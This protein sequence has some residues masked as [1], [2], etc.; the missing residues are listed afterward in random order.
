MEYENNCINFIIIEYEIINFEYIYA[1][2]NNDNCNTKA[3]TNR[4]I[5]NAV[6]VYDLDK[7]VIKLLEQYEAVVFAVEFEDDK[8]LINCLPSNI[9]Y[10]DFSYGSKFNKPIYNYPLLEYIKFGTDFNQSIEYLPITLIILITGSMFNNKV[11]NLPP[12]IKYISLS[13]AFNQCIDTLSDNV[14]ILEIYGNFQQTIN[15]LPEQLEYFKI[16]TYPNTNININNNCF[17]N[18]NSLKE[19][20]LGYGFNSPLDNYRW[21]DTIKS[22]KFDE[23]FNQIITKSNMPKYL[24]TLTV[25]YNFNLDN[26]LDLPDTLKTFIY[27]GGWIITNNNVLIALKKLQNNFHKIKFINR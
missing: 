1:N 22:I 26:I 8:D 27:I 21:S 13:N 10:M 14:I 4:E 17:T 19:I 2:Y 3:N 12:Q 23:E 7:E 15:K 11:D 16:N 18:L 20:D 9:K 6:L 5:I 25:S 24:K